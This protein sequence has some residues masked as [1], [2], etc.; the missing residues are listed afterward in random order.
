MCLTPVGLPVVT[1]IVS[2]RQANFIGVRSSDAPYCFFGRNAF[3]RPVAVSIH[4]FADG[5]DAE[6]AKR[7]WQR[8]LAAVPQSAAAAAG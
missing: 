3:G 2:Y 8:A 5:V 4:S 1:G 6:Q 7:D